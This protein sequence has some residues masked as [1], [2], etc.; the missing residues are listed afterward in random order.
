MFK[1]LLD[2]VQGK[3]KKGQKRSSEWRLFRQK[4]I[5]DQCA[6]CGSETKL[7][8][9]HIVPFNVA[10]DLEL[11]P[12]NVI[13]LCENKKYGINCHLYNGHNGNYRNF[14]LRVKSDSYE[15]KER[16]K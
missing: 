15:S 9:H 5:Q 14:N 12:D 4:Y 11:D 3:A 8:L 7:E 2:R 16:I 13:T 10:P 6:S 1:H